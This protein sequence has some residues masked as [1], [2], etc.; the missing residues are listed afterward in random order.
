MINFVQRKKDRGAA[1]MLFIIFFMFAA[2]ALSFI[3]SRSVFSAVYQQNLLD[4]SKQAYYSAE[5]LVE[6]VSYREVNAL[7]PDA[8]E[9]NTLFGVPVVST[10]TIDTVD[11]LWNIAAEGVYNRVYRKVQGVLA[12]GSGASFNFG[13]QSG[14]GGIQMQNSSE[15]VGNVFS[16][17]P[18]VGG[19]SS[20][21]RGDAISAGSAGLAQ[22]IHATGT[23]RAH[24]IDAIEVD[25]D[26]YYDTEIGASVIFGTR[27]FPEPDQA[28][29]SMPISDEVIELW[30]S[31]IQN[32][33]GTIIAS[34]DPECAGGTYVI[35]FDT[36]IGNLK[37]ECNL[38]FDKNTTVVDLTG[39]VWAVGDVTFKGA[40]VR[41]DASVGSRSVPII[42]H[43]PTS[44]ATSSKVSVVNSSNFY[45][46]GVP[47]SYILVVA[48][49]DDGENGGSEVA[50]D[51]GNSAQGDLLV[52]A[53][54]GIVSMTNN[55][56]LKEVTG[57]RIDMGN[58]T[59][60][61][62]ESGL[63]NQLFTSGPGGGFTIS[64]WG[65]I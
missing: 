55:I 48:M 24:F 40:T 42:A 56:D 41:A 62:Y 23:V 64:D 52:Y 27:Y 28:T 59:T 46:S 3:F 9:T 22:G 10:T 13:L 18:I 2:T 65:E 17:G 12:E 26:A 47:K 37:V 51:I 19:G 49:N 43:N 33:G 63:V 14:T 57:W 54:H 35:D 53:P 61:I 60:V 1:V 50:F 4:R 5:A 25:G 7:G 45:G 11:G 34:T 58:N 32:N 44:T 6:D 8:V 36:T 38:E 21:V 31:N 16:N 15:V 29:A 39:P 30:E 20:L